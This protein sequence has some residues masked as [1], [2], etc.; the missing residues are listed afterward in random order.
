MVT[1]EKAAQFAEA[2][3]VEFARL[4][5]VQTPDDLRNALE[6]LISKSAR[7]V[8]KYCGPCDAL[9]VLNRTT[10]NILP[11]GGRA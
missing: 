6:M 4:C 9:T 5:E 7:A 3:L 10:L 2:T 8:E 11:P 1:P